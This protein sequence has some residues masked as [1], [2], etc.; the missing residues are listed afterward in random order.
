MALNELGN[1]CITGLQ[2]G[3]EGKGKLVDLLVERFDA[4]VRFGGG[5][6]AGHT[7]VVKDERFA[8]HQLPSGILR[9]KVMNVISNGAVVDPAVLLGEIASLQ[10]RGVTIG[11]NFRIS[12]RV[13][14]VF[15]WHRLE[16]VLAE[17]AARGETK[18]G[19]T[20]RGIGPC[21]ADKAGRRFG[22]RLCALFRP[23][24]LRAQIRAATAHKNAVFAALYEQ[25]EE[26]D[27]DAI[28]DEYLA[29]AETLKPFVCDTTQLL[30]GLLRAEKKLLFEGAQGSLLD[31][32][33]GTY[34]YVTSSNAGAGGLSSGAGVPFS[35]V[36]SLIGV[37][38]AYTTRVGTGPFPTEL[39][40]ATGETIRRRGREFGTTTGRPRRCGWFDAHATSYAVKFN[41]PT[42]LA[43]MHLDTLSGLEELQICVGYRL[44][45][46]PVSG[47]PADV[48]TLEAAEPIYETLP[49][50]EAEVTACRRFTDL[51]PNARHYV[52]RISRLL[53]TPIGIVSVGPERDQT[54]FV[55]SEA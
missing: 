26:L 29:F 19:T 6:N 44:D 7:V 55:E 35:A 27:A 47:F 43:L 54:I 9:P 1:T 16:D 4:V 41:G 49:G 22:I 28:T 25:R 21:Y 53:E 12:D 14:L 32:D 40:G 52:N 31:V 50:W 51:P 15:P 38:K 20:S 37:V 2:W 10:E 33:H 5:A 23:E 13:H 8:L 30:H 18:L 46:K 48:Q 3:D 24:Q 45:G 11:D 42:Q 17:K 34:P 39:S 36:R